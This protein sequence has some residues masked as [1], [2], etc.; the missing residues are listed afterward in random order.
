MSAGPV[1]TS[2]PSPSP[3]NQTH[4][5]APLRSG[6]GSNCLGQLAAELMAH[7]MAETG[8]SAEVSGPALF[9]MGAHQDAFRAFLNSNFQPQPQPFEQ[10]PGGRA[11][12]GAAA[13]PAQHNGTGSNGTIGALYETSSSEPGSPQR[14][15]PIA[16]KAFSADVISASALPQQQQ[17]QA[18]QATVPMQHDSASSTD[19]H[20]VQGGGGG[21][22]D[23]AGRAVS[24]PPPLAKNRFGAFA[25]RL[26][27]MTLAVVG[28]Q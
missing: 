7:M 16:G 11:G 9:G 26:Q 25:K 12:G 24:L 15:L 5:P 28:W 4:P 14:A 8:V 21:P 2:T 17:Q 27:V 23:E 13:P 3:E 18:G 10:R 19:L 20:D 22:V 1:E 6:A